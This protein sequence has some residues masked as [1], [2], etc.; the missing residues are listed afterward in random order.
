MKELLHIYNTRPTATSIQEKNAQ[1]LE[2]LVDAL[3]K[4]VDELG[5]VLTFNLK[6][7]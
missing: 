2:L 1:E 6:N 4:K 3:A 7:K 5:Y